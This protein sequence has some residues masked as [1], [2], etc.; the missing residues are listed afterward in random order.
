MTTEFEPTT[1]RR[2]KWVSLSL[3]IGVAVV[4]VHAL[5]SAA[6]SRP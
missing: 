5:L 4:L 1:F 2:T 6:C 3:R